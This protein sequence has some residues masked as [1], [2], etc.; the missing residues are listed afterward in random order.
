ML[1][2]LEV[3]D[4]LLILVEKIKVSWLKY[5]QRGAKYYERIISENCL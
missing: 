1:G 4:S 5:Q 2:F 3:G